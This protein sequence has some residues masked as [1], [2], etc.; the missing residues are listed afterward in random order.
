MLQILSMITLILAQTEAEGISPTTPPPTL[1][2]LPAH[3]EKLLSDPEISD[4]LVSTQVVRVADKKVL[5]ATANMVR[6]V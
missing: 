3:I 4:A 6:T 1:E 2:N 5:Y